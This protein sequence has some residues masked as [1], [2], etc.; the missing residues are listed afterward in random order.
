MKPSLLGFFFL[1]VV[2]SGVQAQGLVPAT[3]EISLG[4]GLSVP[5]DQ[6]FNHAADTGP[7]LDVRIGYV[8]TPRA[9]VGGEFVWTRNGVSD[10]PRPLFQRFP[11]GPEV[12]SF[13]LFQFAL[14]SKVLL[15]PKSVAP[16]LDTQLGVYQARVNLDVNGQSARASSTSPGVAAG[17]GVQFRAQGF[18]DGFAGAR[19]H[20]TLDEGPT[21]FLTIQ[22][23]IVHY[24]GT[25]RAQ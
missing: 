11:L 14:F 15:V 13:D 17:A 4:T 8:A 20:A 21:T 18:V 19:I 24:L 23:G 16:Y 12:V 9:I 25:G 3:V 1:V 6:D 2:S 5:I 7:G 22:F 10:A